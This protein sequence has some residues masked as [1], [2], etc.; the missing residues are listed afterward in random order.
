MVVCIHELLNTVL[1]SVTSLTIFS[2]LARCTDNVIVIWFD[3]VRDESKTRSAARYLQAQKEV[4]TA[5]T[6]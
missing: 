3:T 5:S 4:Y 6:R 1:I 2:V